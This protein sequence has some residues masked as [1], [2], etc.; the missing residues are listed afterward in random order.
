MNVAIF[1]DIAPYSPNMNR[2][3]G[4]TYRLHVQGRKL[5]EQESSVQQVAGSFCLW[6]LLCASVAHSDGSFFLRCMYY[7]CVTLI[8]AVKIYLQYFQ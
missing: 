1:W 2:R 8:I 3:F 6:S 4:G 7:G 5:A